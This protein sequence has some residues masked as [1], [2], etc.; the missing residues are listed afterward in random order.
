MEGNCQLMFSLDTDPNFIDS[1]VKRNKTN[2]TKQKLI[3]KW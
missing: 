1:N 2:K 3:E